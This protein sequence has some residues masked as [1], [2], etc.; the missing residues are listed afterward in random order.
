MTLTPSF[1]A[2]WTVA[3]ISW[4]ARPP[5]PPGTP[6]PPDVVGQDAPVPRL[7]RVADSL[8]DAIRSQHGRLEV[9][10]REQVELLLAIVVAGDRPLHLEVIAPAAELDPLVA[11]V[12]DLGRDQ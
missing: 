9:V 4:V 2:A 8:A 5:N 6:A 7:D 11:P 3:S 12:G 1:W 10:A